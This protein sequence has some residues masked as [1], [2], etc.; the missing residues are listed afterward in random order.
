M[1]QPYLLARAAGGAPP[2]VPE[3]RGA[4][5][6]RPRSVYLRVDRRDGLVIDISET[7]VLVRLPVLQT[8]DALVPIS[9]MWDG[10]SVRMRGRIIRAVP[11]LVEQKSGAPHRTE[12]L[13]AVEFVDVPEP[14]A[15]RLQSLIQAAVAESC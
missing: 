5:R 14:A 2:S 10:A 1:S 12:Y 7:G 4:E 9:L 6:R 8:P 15:R 11:I 13:V 3:R